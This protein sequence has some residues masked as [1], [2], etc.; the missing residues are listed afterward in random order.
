[1]YIYIYIYIYYIPGTNQN[2][3]FQKKFEFV[4][5]ID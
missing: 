1:M 3:I 5:A 4:F 2:K